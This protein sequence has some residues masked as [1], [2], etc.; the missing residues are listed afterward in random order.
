MKEVVK[1]GKPEKLIAE[2][3]VPKYHSVRKEDVQC[4]LKSK[5]LRNLK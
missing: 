4:D 1:T 3:I 2:S 5:C